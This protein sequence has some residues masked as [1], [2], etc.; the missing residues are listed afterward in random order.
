MLLLNLK[1]LKCISNNH[2]S[3]FDIGMLTNFIYITVSFPI[4][5]KLTAYCKHYKCEL[6]FGFKI[7]KLC[8]KSKGIL[9]VCEL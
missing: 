7:D 2:K 9:C 3:H 4:L 1:I 5:T 6:E 8:P